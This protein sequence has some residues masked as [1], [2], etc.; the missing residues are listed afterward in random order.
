MSLFT[1]GLISRGN[2]ELLWAHERYLDNTLT[3]ARKALAREG[4]PRREGVHCF[5]G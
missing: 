1:E 5:Q 2:A 4:D 3:E